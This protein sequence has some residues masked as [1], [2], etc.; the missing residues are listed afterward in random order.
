MTRPLSPQEFAAV[1]KLPGRE[2]YAHFIKQVADAEEVWSLASDTGWVIAGDDDGRESVPVWSHPDYAAACAIGEWAGNT[3]EVILLD[4]WI[5]AWLPGIEGDGRSIAVFLVPG[6]TS[7]A[8]VEP[9][10]LGLDLAAALEN[11]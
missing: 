4:E 8:T 7:A 6:E 3:P 9:A 5:D 1:S 10:R 2:R 11:S